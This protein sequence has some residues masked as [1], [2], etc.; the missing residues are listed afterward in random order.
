MTPTDTL[1]CGWPV[2]TAD[3]DH[4]HSPLLKRGALILVTVGMSSSWETIRKENFCTAF[5]KMAVLCS[6]WPPRI[7]C[8]AFRPTENGSRPGWKSGPKR[9]IP[10]WLILLPA[11]P[12]FSSSRMAQA[13]ELHTLRRWSIGHPTPNI[14]TSVHRVESMPCLFPLVK[15]FRACHPQDF[16]IQR[17][18]T[19]SREHGSSR[20]QGHNLPDPTLR[21]TRIRRKTRS[22]T[23]TACLYPDLLRRHHAP[24]KANDH[25]RS[26][27]FCERFLL[28]N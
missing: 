24:R 21:F 7:S 9:G 22:G 17:T 5:A 27:G 10:S 25:H 8:T 6:P 28:S 15:S 3:P 2:S 11:D 19:R 18:Q 13:R 1:H 23:F 20:R 26:P 4:G 12:Q 16:L 14:F